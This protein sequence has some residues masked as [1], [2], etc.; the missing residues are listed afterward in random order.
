MI[1]KAMFAFAGALIIP[2]VVGIAFFEPIKKVGVEVL[3]RVAGEQTSGYIIDSVEDFDDDEYGRTFWHHSV[4]YRFLDASGQEIIGAASGP[5]RL[6]N[7]FARVDKEI[8]IH[9]EY[10]P[11][12]PSISR[13]FDPSARPCVVSL[14]FRSLLAFGFLCGWLWFVSQSYKEMRQQLQGGS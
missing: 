11:A 12:N 7:R 9:V 5:G 3:L 14:V 8:P 2:L 6:N 4:A 1:R 10:L 13:P